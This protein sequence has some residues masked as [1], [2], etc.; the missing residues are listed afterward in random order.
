MSEVAGARTFHA[1]GEAYD[2][3]MGRYSRALATPFADYCGLRPGLRF[4]DVGCGPGALTG[5]ASA[6]LG[7]AAVAGLDPSPDFVQACR[8]RCPGV[9]VRLGSAEQ[10]PY[11][12]D[13][14]DCAAAQLVFHFLSDPAGAVAGM[15]R[16]VRPG[17]VIAAS[18]WDFADGM[19]MLRTFWDAALQVDPSA[20]DEARLR[21]GAPGELSAV[22]TEGGLVEVEESTLTVSS[23]YSGFEELWS[24]FLAG[25]GP[26]GAYTVA[27]PPAQQELLRAA[28]LERLGWSGAGPFRLQA[29]ARVARARVS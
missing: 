4:L 11:E 7:P 24:G 13:E 9:E 29:V 14:F 25:I 27:Q 10:I 26:V 28:L 15:G 19:Q 5:V 18:V 16:V 12:D 20:P 22:F 6:R 8:E 1:S 21:F 3:F 23:E 17:G 2:R